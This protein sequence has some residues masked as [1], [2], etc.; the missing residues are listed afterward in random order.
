MHAT[1]AIIAERCEV[2]DIIPIT[3]KRETTTVSVSVDNIMKA[4][5]ANT[6]KKDARTTVANT[7]EM[8]QQKTMDD[9][10]SIDKSSI[11][12]DVYSKSF[13]KLIRDLGYD[14]LPD[15]LR[16]NIG[17]KIYKIDTKTEKITFQSSI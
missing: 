13:S 12:P 16:V 9:F 5:E 17:N 3:P 11:A 4:R 2:G 7:M 1:K 15:T 6:E 10:L 14:Y 8:E